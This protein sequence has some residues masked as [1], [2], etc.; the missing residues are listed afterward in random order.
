VQIL[1]AEGLMDGSERP[2]MPLRDKSGI[3]GRGALAGQKA[4]L[5]KALF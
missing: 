4:G 2:Q 3:L 1:T 5:Q